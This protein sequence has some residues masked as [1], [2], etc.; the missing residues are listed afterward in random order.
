VKQGG[1]IERGRKIGHKELGEEGG[2]RV[3]EEKEKQQ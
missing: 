2:V 1:G 3:D